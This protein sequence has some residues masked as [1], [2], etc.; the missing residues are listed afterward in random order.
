MTK[1]IEGLR[2][3]FQAIEIIENLDCGIN[4]VEVDK[5]VDTKGEKEAT[6][7]LDCMEVAYPKA[8]ES[9]DEFLGMSKARKS[10]PML[11]PRY[12]AIFDKKAAHQVEFMQLAKWKRD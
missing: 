12:N 11:C 1:A 9:L 2:E 6:P 10:E 7:K 3:K 5:V 4:M 8:E